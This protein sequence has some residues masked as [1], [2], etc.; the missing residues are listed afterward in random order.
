[1]NEYIE[2]IIS[3]F[4]WFDW[5]IVTIISISGLY[6][7]TRGFIKEAVTVTA[8][9][10]AAWV[11][12][13][14]ADDL[15][16]YLEPHIETSSMRVALMVLAVFIVVLSLSSILRQVFRLIIDKVGLVG[17]DH[18]LGLVFGVFRGAVLAMLLMI[19]LL[20]LGFGNDKWWA[21]SFMVEKLSGIMDMIP[22][23]LPDEA[24]SVY[25]RVAMR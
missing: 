10:F 2:S 14:Y 6:G 1:M 17:L 11:S 8:W 15:A 18:V 20:N 25:K 13:V 9:V 12:Y 3:L 24:K 4:N 5:I 22:E 21:D 7:I 16:I 23:H 19:A